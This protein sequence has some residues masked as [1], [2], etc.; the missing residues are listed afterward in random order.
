M[1]L[2]RVRVRGDW[3]EEAD[4][5]AT[6]I[7]H[8]PDVPLFHWAPTARRSGINRHGLRPLMRATVSTG[9]RAPYVCFADTPRW[10]WALSGGMRWTPTGDWDLWQTW[11][12]DLGELPTIVP[13]DER[14]SGIYEVRTPHRVF[15]RHLWHV[16]TRTKN[17]RRPR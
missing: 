13:T 3:D 7:Q 11:L 16:G 10:A 5:Y 4:D 17:A 8:L 1:S 12:S 14:Q 6:T 2:V 9:W 15:K